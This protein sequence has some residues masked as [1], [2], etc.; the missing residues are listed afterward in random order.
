MLAIV[1][2]N[3]I[4]DVLTG[5]K[6]LGDVAVR[7]SMESGGLKGTNSDWACKKKNYYFSLTKMKPKSNRPTIRNKS[8]ALLVSGSC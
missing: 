5:A 3:D 7:F 6:V 4:N 1:P 8:S 2:S